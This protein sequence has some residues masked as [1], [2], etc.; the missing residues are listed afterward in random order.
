MSVTLSDPDPPTAKS[1]SK[2]RSGQRRTLNRL[3]WA[4][5]G[6]VI[7]AFGQAAFSRGSLW[8]GLL[9]YLIAVILFVRAMTDHPYPRY[10]FS[11]M[12]PKLANTLTIRLG[13]RRFVGI[14]LFL[15]AAGVSVLAYLA[16]DGEDG[17]S[18]AWWLYGAGILS[19]V[20]GGLVLMPGTSPVKL[21]HQ[22]IPNREAALGLSLILAIALFMRLYNFTEQPFGIWFD[23]AEAGLRARQMIADPAYRPIFY[24]AINVTGHFLATYAVALHWLGNTIYSMRL[25]S[26]MFGLGG[27]I[28]AYLFG[29]ELRGVRFGLAMAF[30][31]AVARWHVNFSRIAMTGVDTIFFEFLSLYFLLRLFRR[32]HLRDAMWAGLVLGLGLMYYSAF[33]LFI[34]ALVIFSLVVILRW[35]PAVR[36]A[37]VDGG[38]R[39]YLGGVAVLIL[40]TWLVAMP[41]IRFALDNP[42]SFWYRTRQI[43]IFT[44]RDQADLWLALG[45]STQKHLLMFNFQGDKNGR[46]NL[47]GKPMLDPVMAIL[48]VLGL[49]LALARTRY[50]ANTFFLILFPV[51]LIGGI[52]S[53]DF[54]APQSLRSIAVIPAIIYFAALALAAVGREMEQALR[55]LPKTWIMAPVIAVAGFM[56]LS[57][58]FTYFS[59]QANDFASWNAFSAPETITGRE[60]AKLGPDYAYILSPFLTNHPT[61]RFLAPDITRQQFLKLPDALPIRDPSGRPVALFLH[62]DDAG[63]VEQAKRIY[64]NAEYEI[65]S[66]PA[67]GAAEI[68]PESVHLIKTQPSDL[69]SV[70]GLEL[71]YWAAGETDE[72]TRIFQ[73]SLTIKPGLHR[74][75]PLARRRSG[76][77]R[78]CRRV[79][80]HS[81]CSALRSL[82]LSIGGARIGPVGDRWQRRS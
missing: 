26:V 64:P 66:G 25:V 72:Q 21:W 24:T 81:L 37:L 61:T 65:F 71:R 45:E 33:R 9:L 49:G 50:A 31:V 74:R 41:L 19:A 56:L 68:G 8:D 67:Q 39:R 13:W 46:H 63:V 47:P 32:G 55:P 30:L 59:T 53:V 11:L 52:F 2:S 18:Q 23:E 34:L 28:A 29:R 48:F 73:R 82:R 75:Y 51:A 57:N 22:I 27:V 17:F 40:S 5:L 35:W 70:R 54:E 10:K 69:M 3:A 36:A 42:D 44:K 80:R 15:L 78:F 7:G 43:S 77:S 12:N 20:A 14:W 16:F 76:R 79:E 1:V 62:P 38:W 4:G 6:F 60:M 58:A